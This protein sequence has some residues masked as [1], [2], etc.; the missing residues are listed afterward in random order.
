MSTAGHLLDGRIVLVNG[1][2]TGVGAGVTPAPATPRGGSGGG[3]SPGG[4]GSTAND[5]STSSPEQGCTAR[6]L[7]ADLGDPLAARGTVEEV[8]AAFGRIDSLV[9]SAGLTSRGTLLERD[10]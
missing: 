4:P 2:T 1:G 3:S 7:H 5:S 9:N 10:A 6:Y 8:V